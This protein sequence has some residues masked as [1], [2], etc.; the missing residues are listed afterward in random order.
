M[1]ALDAIGRLDPALPTFAEMV[2]LAARPII[3]LGQCERIAIWSLTGR[4]LKGA[5][6]GWGVHVWEDLRTLSQLEFNAL[7]PPLD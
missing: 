4:R 1:D 5:L 7:V 3:L 2:A 6:R